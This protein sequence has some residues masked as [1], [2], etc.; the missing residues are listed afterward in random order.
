VRP[1]LGRY[2]SS[3]PHRTQYLGIYNY[4]YKRIIKGAAPSVEVPGALCAAFRFFGRPR[5]AALAGTYE[6]DRAK[7]EQVPVL[8]LD[9]YKYI[10]IYEYMHIH[11]HTHIYI[12]IYIYIHVYICIMHIH[13]SIYL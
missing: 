2:L 11:T 5:R 8:N 7:C 3:L 1:H 9:M 10:H 13:T 6:R 12:Y 4:V